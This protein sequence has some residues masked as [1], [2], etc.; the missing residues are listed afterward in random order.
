MHATVKLRQL[1]IPPNVKALCLY[2][3]IAACMLIGSLS[4]Y[5]IVN[6]GS[7]KKDTK[8]AHVQHLQAQPSHGPMFMPKS[9]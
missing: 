9:Q 7:V 4:A 6:S 2:F 5:A 8:P 1:H 3:S